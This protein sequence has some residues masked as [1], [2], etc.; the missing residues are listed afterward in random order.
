MTIIII[1]IIIPTI[2]NEDSSYIHCF[3]SAQKSYKH[4]NQKDWLHDF[5]L[6]IITSLA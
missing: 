2:I 6:G 1:I 3:K 5:Q 4:F